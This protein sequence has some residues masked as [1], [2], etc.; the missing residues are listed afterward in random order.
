MCG[1]KCWDSIKEL[2]RGLSRTTQ[3]TKV[4]IKKADSTK[5]TTAAQKLDRFEEY[6][7]EHVYGRPPSFDW[8]AAGLV[9][10]QPILHDTMT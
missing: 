3:S 6:F 9:D 4:S 1:K 2:H 10:Q 8:E 7:Q 5:C